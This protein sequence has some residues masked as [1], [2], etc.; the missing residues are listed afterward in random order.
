[1]RPRFLIP[2]LD[3][4]RG[5]AVLSAEE[6][7]HLTRVLRL[8]IGDEVRVFDGRGQEYVARVK[9]TGRSAATVTLLNPVHEQAA[10]QVA[11][12]LVQSILKADAMESVVRDCVMVG[13]ESIQ[14]IVSERTT[15]KTSTLPKAVKRWRR[16]ALASTKQCGRSTL[17][18]ILEALSFDD[19]LRARGS[20][21][22]FLLVE[23]AVA[24][25]DALTIR[26]LFERPA[27]ERASLVIGPEGGWTSAER[28]RAIENGCAP[29]SLGRLTLRAE[30]VPLAA[31]AALLAVWQT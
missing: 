28:V 27:P 22:S 24:G 11:L 5:D 1:M 10:P 3:P 18:T 15:V 9:S 21:T 4:D 29:L 31:T 23:P 26:D 8:G 19:W 7:H 16:V 13:V 6:A 17:A 2:D 30:S 25:D 20:E 14:P 12:R